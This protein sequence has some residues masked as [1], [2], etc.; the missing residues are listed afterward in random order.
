MSNSKTLLSKVYDGES[1]VDIER[2]VNDA[3]ENTDVPA[4]ENGFADGTYRVVITFTATQKGIL[5]GKVER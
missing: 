3:I 5:A 1:I 4:D 2:D